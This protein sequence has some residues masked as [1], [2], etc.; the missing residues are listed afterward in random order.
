MAAPGP[1]PLAALWSMLR[2]RLLRKPKPRGAGGAD[3]S[4]LDPIL[5][6]VERSGLAALPEQ[7]DALDGYIRRLA[8]IDPDG[9][10]RSGA[11]A[12]WLNLYNAGALDLARRAH[13][14]EAETVL[15]IPGAF[16]E[17]FVEVAGEQLSLDGIEHGKVRRFGDPRV[18]TALVCGSA[19]CPTLRHESYRAEGLD[20][21]L[22]AQTRSFLAAGGV[23]RAEDVVLL[24]RVFLWYGGDWSRP[25][26]MPTLLP[27]RKSR[28][29][30]AL[31]PWLGHDTRAWIADASPSIG[32]QPYDWSLACSVGGR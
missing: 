31:S 29:V 7:G 10:S 5:T 20:R 12:Y 30:D 21:Q 25:D 14:R 19:S 28:I 9:L 23:V 24:S 1:N 16:G 32:F 8:D 4:G 2:A 27:A 18:H 15:R 13:Q 22:D 3:L 6:A 17:P 26:R 11:L